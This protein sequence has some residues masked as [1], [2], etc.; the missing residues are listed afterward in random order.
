MSSVVFWDCVWATC[1]LYFASLLSPFRMNR[2][3]QNNNKRTTHRPTKKPQQKDQLDLSVCVAWSLVALVFLA[4]SLLSSSLSS[5]S[6]M[7]CRVCRGRNKASI[8]LSVLIFWSLTILALA[9]LS[10]GVNKQCG[11]ENG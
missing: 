2:T 6:S 7:S 9:L 4:L 5:D 10:L 3:R 1:L 8:F 11:I